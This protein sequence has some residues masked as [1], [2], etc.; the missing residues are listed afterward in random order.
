MRKFFFLIAFA[1]LA[2]LIMTA[3][4]SKSTK[5]GSTEGDPNDQGFILAKPDAD[6]TA[7]ELYTDIVEDGASISPLIVLNGK[8]LADTVVYDTLTGWHIRTRTDSLT[9]F[10]FA[11]TDSFRFSDSN[12][13]FTRLPDSLTDIFQRHFKKTFTFERH[14]GADT[15]WTKERRR[16][17]RWE[18]LADSV[19]VLN[20]DFYRHWTGDNERRLFDRTVQGTLDSLKFHSA[21]LFNH[22]YPHPF[23]GTLISNMVMD[24][25]TPNRTVHLEGTLTITFYSDHYHARLVRGDNWWE[26]D[27]YYL[28]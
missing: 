23:S 12:D 11:L 14:S 8:I 1:G 26:W 6:S 28:P 5:T 3:G 21:D 19:T 24:V 17:V 18:G 25:Q 4:C 2:I 7:A 15:A 20:G 16:N 10:Q 22:V 27:H 9:W 13:Q